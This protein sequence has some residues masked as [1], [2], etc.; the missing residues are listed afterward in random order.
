[1]YATN[2]ILPRA[3]DTGTNS[4]NGLPSSQGLNNMFLQLLVAQLQ[5]QNPLDP[6]DPTQFVGQLAQFSELSAVTQIEQLLAEAIP[7][8]SATGTPSP[9]PH[10]TEEKV[11]AVPSGDIGSAAAT[12]AH[13]S[14]PEPRSFP[15]SM[16][17]HQIQGVF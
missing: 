17:N 15:T 3:A 11:G 1:M 9:K 14:L 5:N 13:A 6:M 16:F 12:T 10:A 7:S 8:T 4:S 2:P